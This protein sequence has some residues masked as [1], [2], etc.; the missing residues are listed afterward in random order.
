M[1]T[2]R[3][4]LPAGG[5][6]PKSDRYSQFMNSSLIPES[7]N[8]LATSSFVKSPRYKLFA[9]RFALRNITR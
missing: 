3:T 1:P 9:D 2:T 5:N 7:A 8:D 4:Q 6:A